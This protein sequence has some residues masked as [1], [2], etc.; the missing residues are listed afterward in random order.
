MKDA[1]CSLLMFFWFSMASAVSADPINI[2]QVI[3]ESIGEFSV[4]VYWLSDSCRNVYQKTEN[5]WYLVCIDNGQLSAVS[6]PAP[7]HTDE[8]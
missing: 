4:D 1:I 7:L 3:K 2:D 5:Q 8:K 6:V